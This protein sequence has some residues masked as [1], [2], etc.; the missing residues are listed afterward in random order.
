M[1]K[2]FDGQNLHI[3]IPNSA[4]MLFRPAILFVCTCILFA[5]LS[6][7]AHF[8][9]LEYKKSIIG[10]VNNSSFLLCKS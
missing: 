6:V 4:R 5:I 2:L 9:L 1:Y 3:S 7:F 10:G 8:M